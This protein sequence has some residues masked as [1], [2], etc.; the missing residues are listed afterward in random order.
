MSTKYNFKKTA[1]YPHPLPML[2]LKLI[3]LDTGQYLHR[4]GIFDTGAD[5]CLCPAGDAIRLGHHLKGEG[6]K[7]KS[8]CGA[9]N[10]FDTYIHTF[11]ICLMQPKN[12]KVLF[13]KK[14]GVACGEH[15]P[16]F[17]LGRNLFSDC[18]VTIDFKK[19]LLV[20]DK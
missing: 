14:I 11:R 13:S 15:C 20:I 10:L 1:G 16:T 6:V 19:A 18:K 12:N 17:L 2:P 8:V 9:G 4:F 5:S 7:K 3:N